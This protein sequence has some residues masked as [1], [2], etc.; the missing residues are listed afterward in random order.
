MYRR[1]RRAYPSGTGVLLNIIR[2]P[3]EVICRVDARA[4]RYLDAEDLFQQPRQSQRG[5]R[6]AADVGKPRTAVQILGTTSQRG[7][8]CELDGSRDRLVG[9]AASQRT[10]QFLLIFDTDCWGGRGGREPLTQEELLNLARRC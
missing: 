9:T 4:D 2:Q 3:V 10:Q 5:Q 1:E 8:H 6:I 7:L